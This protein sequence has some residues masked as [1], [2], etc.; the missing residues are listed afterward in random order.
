MAVTISLKV[1]IGAVI[2]LNLS[3]L[4]F[5]LYI[6]LSSCR[7]LNIFFILGMIIEGLSD[8]PSKSAIG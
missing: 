4:M 3:S 2:L 8:F 1:G 7:Y 5:I 6:S